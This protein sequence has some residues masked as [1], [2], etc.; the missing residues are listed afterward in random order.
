MGY[1][2]I[3]EFFCIFSHFFGKPVDHWGVFS[4]IIQFSLI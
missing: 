1:V 4:Y 2:A 3:R